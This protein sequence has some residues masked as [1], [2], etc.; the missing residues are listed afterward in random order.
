MRRLRKGRKKIN[1]CK[2]FFFGCHILHFSFTLKIESFFSLF[3][4]S[5]GGPKSFSFSSHFTPGK[6]KKKRVG[7][8]DE[9]WLTS[10]PTILDVSIEGKIYIYGWDWTIERRGERVFSFSMLIKSS[11]CLLP[12]L[13]FFF[14][15]L[16]IVDEG[17]TA[18][19]D[20]V[21][22]DFLL[23]FRL[24][25]LSLLRARSARPHTIQKNPVWNHN[26][27]IHR[28]VMPPRT[29]DGR[30]DDQRRARGQHSC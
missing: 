12:L 20:D 26:F 27:S 17:Q 30:V 4:R 5:W 29:K 19:V 16:L 1:D 21:E 11:G 22:K 23:K 2:T 3:L 18:T 10:L 8:R 25:L 13:S 24:P 14:L 6:S 7:V 28:L 15:L 9:V